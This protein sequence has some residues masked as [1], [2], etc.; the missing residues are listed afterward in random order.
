MWIEHTMNDNEDR[1]VMVRQSSGGAL[2]KADT[3]E[4]LGQLHAVQDLLRSAMAEGQDYG[5][6]PGCGDKPTLLQPGAQKIGLLFRLC[7]DYT[8]QKEDLGSGHREYSVACKLTNTNGS[9][10]GSGVGSCATT[11]SKFRYRNENTNR[12]V[13]SEY[14][15]NR[16]SSLLGGPT[17]TARKVKGEWFI[18]QQVEHPNPADYFN[19][20]LKMAK[21]RAYVDAIL[22]RTGASQVFSQDLEDMA[23]NMSVHHA[24]PTPEPRPQPKPQPRPAPAVAK[25][26]PDWTQDTV[27]MGEESLPPSSSE[28]SEPTQDQL[29]R[30]GLEA[31]AMTQEE[32]EQVVIPF[33]KNKGLALGDVSKGV[34]WSMAERWQV[35]PF[36]G[37]FQHKD[38][39]LQAQARRLRE[40]L[41]E[42]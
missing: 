14:W 18:Y 25:P 6:I 12:P 38:L 17:F 10:V 11:E 13:P 3:N 32:L 8:I 19:T 33:G 7:P 22:T 31:E 9:F 36:R 2:E 30:A 42:Q 15:K 34:R 39:L 16:D 23:D 29:N 20:C 28:P 5:K 37:E 27:P 1:Q 4:V 21:K 41:G 24:E 35:K 26:D 40:L